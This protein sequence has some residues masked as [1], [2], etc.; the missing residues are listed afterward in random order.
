M[1]ARATQHAPVIGYVPS[2]ERIRLHL[3]NHLPERFHRWLY[4]P[5]FERCTRHVMRVAAPIARQVYDVRGL[6]DRESVD[7][8]GHRDTQR[9]TIS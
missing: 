4:A 6:R 5:L 2:N 9:L 3:M 8:G 7:A 1:R